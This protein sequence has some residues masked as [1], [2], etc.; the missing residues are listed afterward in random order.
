MEPTPPLPVFP[1]LSFLDFMY[2]KSMAKI[3]GTISK[4]KK[5]LILILGLGLFLSLIP[6]HQAQA[7]PWDSVVNAIRNLPITIPALV[8]AIPTFLITMVLGFISTAISQILIIFIQNLLQ[9]SITH[10][11]F[12][13]VGWSLCRDLA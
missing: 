3:L 7:W 1:L 6:L 11:D 10:Q 13:I 2:N 5:T 12:V 8:V 4:K 9:V